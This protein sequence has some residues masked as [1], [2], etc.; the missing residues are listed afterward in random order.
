MDHVCHSCYF[1]VSQ[2]NVT[3]YNNNKKGIDYL[4]VKCQTQVAVSCARSLVAIQTQINR[5]E[6]WSWSVREGV[7][8]GGLSTPS[9]PS[10]EKW[11]DLCSSS[12]LQPNS[13]P[14]RNR[15]EYGSPALGVAWTLYSDRNFF[16]TP[17][18]DFFAP[19]CAK[20][21]ESQQIWFCDGMAMRLTWS[22]LENF[23]WL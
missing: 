6:H 18:E 20:Y 15:A 19:L 1:C 3:I 22:K 8:E 10:P 9:A 5:E 21:Y 23:S 4:Y 16:F 2:E 14:S 12:P 13:E 11:R 17:P 7:A